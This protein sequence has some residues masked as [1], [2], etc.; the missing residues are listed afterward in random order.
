MSKPM[1]MMNLYREELKAMAR[2]LHQE[3][4]SQTAIGKELG[5]PRPTITRWL[6]GQ[7]GQNEQTAPDVQNDLS[8]TKPRRYLVVCDRVEKFHPPPGIT[9][10]LI[11]P[12]LGVHVL[13]SP[14]V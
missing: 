4:F 5:V 8:N 3:G 10:P 1:R 14:P 2:T 13:S 7:I 11:K 12:N 6:K 9:F